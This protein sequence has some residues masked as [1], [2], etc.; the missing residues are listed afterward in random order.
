MPDANAQPTT[1]GGVA[2]NEV[3]M[4][5]PDYKYPSLMRSNLAYDREL[6]FLGLVGT[7]E[8]L[9]SQNVNDVNYQNLNLRRSARA[10]RRPSVLRAHREHADHRRDPA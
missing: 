9:Y 8:F 3:D 6:G 5:D 10:I 1:V 2:S 4:I 7:A